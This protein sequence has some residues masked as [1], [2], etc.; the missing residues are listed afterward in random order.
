MPSAMS[1]YL[2]KKLFEVQ[3][4]HDYFLTTAD[5]TS[6][7]E[8]N[9]TEKDDLLSQKLAHNLYDL[10]NIFTIE[11]NEDTKLRMNEYGLIFTETALGF[12]VG[13][14]VLSENLAGATVYRPYLTVPAS[15]SLSFSIQPLINHFISIT[16]LCFRTKLPAVYYFS[17]RDKE[18]LD[19]VTAPPYASLQLANKFGEHQTGMKHEMGAL[20]NFGGTLREAIQATDGSI[21]AHWEDVEDRGF[22]SNAD[23]ILLPNNFTYF[24]DIEDAITELKFVL[25]DESSSQIK[26]ITKSSSAILQNVPLNFSKVDE[27]DENSNDI[28]SGMYTL[29]VKENTG[30]EI[31]YP[32]YLNESLYNKNAFGIID[33]RFDEEDSPFS[34]LDTAG[35]LKTRITAADVLLPH[36]VFEIRFKNRR[37]Y[38]RYQSEAGFSA[39]DILD[40][41]GHLDDVSGKLVSKKPKALTQSLVPFIN[42]TSQMLPHPKI[43]GIRVEKE[44]TFSE[45][46]INQSNRLLNS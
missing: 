18:V 11:A 33:I 14:R 17:N 9:K 40:T 3:I 37:T 31:A 32:I 2:F 39:Q 36:P 25:E 38:W 23:R 27:T 6:F 26:T 15:V 16:S 34:L 45:I 20:I 22:A 4:L 29:K 41:S 35:F 42:G 28:P 44:K 43:S 7:F 24:P 8:R 19:E 30:P 1:E 10:R 5:A 46:Y 12:I 13:Q 21:P